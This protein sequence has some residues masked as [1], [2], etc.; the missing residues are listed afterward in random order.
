MQVCLPSIP[1][2]DEAYLLYGRAYDTV[3]LLSRDL[4]TL[5][6]LART[7]LELKEFASVRHEPKHVHL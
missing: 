4:S 5:Y 2:V 6:H 7:S 3:G 1:E